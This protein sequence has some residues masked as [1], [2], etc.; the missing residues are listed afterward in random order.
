VLL[1]DLS[2]SFS[3]EPVD[4]EELVRKRGVVS[5][6]CNG[7]WKAWGFPRLPLVVERIV[8]FVKPCLLLRV[9][10]RLTL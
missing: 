2:G 5:R 4:C 1:A 10:Q 7:C 8:E 9:K 3:S 6:G